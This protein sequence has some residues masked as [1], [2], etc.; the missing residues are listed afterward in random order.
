[1]TTGH[2]VGKDGRVKDEVKLIDDDDV[3]EMPM[4]LGWRTEVRCSAAEFS[5]SCA[6]ISLGFENCP[7]CPFFHNGT[8]AFDVR[9]KML[10]LSKAEQKEGTAVF[11]KS[12]LT[13]W[14]G[15]AD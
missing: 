7:S 12:G 5:R 8:I 6:F 1:M 15:Q 14:A 4:A 9:S 13:A 11:Y 3:V 10:G 2:G